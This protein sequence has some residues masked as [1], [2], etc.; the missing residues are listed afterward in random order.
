MP[1]EFLNAV[2]SGAKV[3]TKKLPGGKYIHLAKKNGK[4]IVGEVKKK[5]VQ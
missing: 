5:K 1:Q 3:I 2:N 4:W